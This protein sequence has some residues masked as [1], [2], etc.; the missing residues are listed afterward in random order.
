MTAGAAADVLDAF[1]SADVFV[2][3]D[4]G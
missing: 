3:V 1:D 4:G 2:V